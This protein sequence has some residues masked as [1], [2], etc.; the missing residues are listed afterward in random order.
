MAR[1]LFATLLILLGCLAAAYQLTS[2]FSTWTSEAARRAA[3]ARTPRQLPATT[4]HLADGSEVALDRWLAS[5]TPLT[6]AGF[7][8]TRCNSL[9]S[10]LRDEFQRLQAE[11]QARQLQ[12]KVRLLSIS[13]DPRNDT[14]AELVS[15]A[16]RMR[17]DP[18]VWQFASVADP[19]QLQGLLDQFGIVV[20]PDGLGGYVHN[21]ALHIVDK[22]ARLAD[23]EDLGAGRQALAAA[24]ALGERR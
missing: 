23:I 2:G 8:Y 20:V 19:A 21:A 11:I 10:I 3:I 6:I 9:C 22:Q 12:G 14:P 17:A 1:T 7:I 5:G 4:L 18:A 16:A 24:I 13:F 15:Y